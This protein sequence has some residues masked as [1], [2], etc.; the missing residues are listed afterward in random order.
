[1]CPCTYIWV[2]PNVVANSSK[3]LHARM[4]DLHSY[5]ETILKSKQTHQKKKIICVPQD[6]PI[7]HIKIN[8]SCHICMRHAALEKKKRDLRHAGLSIMN[9]TWMSHVTWAW[10]MPY[11]KKMKSVSIRSWIS[12]EWG[13]FHMYESI[14]FLS[15]FNSETRF[16][17]SFWVSTPAS[18]VSEWGKFHL[19]ESCHMC[20]SHAI[21]FKK[22]N[23]CPTGLSDH[24]Y[25][26]NE[27][28][29]ICM[30]HVT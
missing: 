9:S 4:D 2:M 26:V 10:V 24:E 21:F 28:R 22:R 3:R 18:H 15:F 25:H 6:Y 27:A 1:M 16:S 29:F 13:T 20:M 11:S 5:S 23:L 14:L 19:Y 7:M 8:M 30:S 17:L 12:R